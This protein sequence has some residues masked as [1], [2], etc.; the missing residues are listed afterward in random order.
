MKKNL[1]T[2]LALFVV[3]GACLLSLMSVQSRILDSV[4]AY[5]WTEGLYSKAQ[6]DAI[7]YLNTYARTRDNNEYLRFVDLLEFNETIRQ[8]REELQSEHPDANVATSLLMKNG[9][10][11]EDAQNMVWL[12]LNFSN[13]PYMAES[14]SI[15]EKGDA[16]IKEVRAAGQAISLSVTTDPA[17]DITRQIV[18]VHELN[19]EL[20]ALE[21]AFSFTLNTGA[22][23]IH[24][25]LFWTNFVTALVLACVSIL[26]GRGVVQNLRKHETALVAHGDRLTE[27]VRER[28]R[29]LEI[30][31]QELRVT[32]EA[33]DAANRAKSDF[34]AKM[35]HEIRTPM[36]AIVGMSHLALE[37]SLDAEAQS[38]VE[39][40]HL[41]SKIIISILNDILDL[42]KVEADKLVLESIDFDLDELLQTLVG[43]VSVNAD[44]KKIDILLDIDGD[45]LAA[46][47]G[48]PHRLGQV[49]TN[50]LNNAIKFSG[51]GGE[52]VLRVARDDSGS[53]GSSEMLCF[54][55][56]DNGIGIS[57]EGKAKLFQAFSQADS[58]V[59]RRYGGTGLGLMIS[60]QL[61]ELMGGKIWVE[62]EH[63]KGSVFHFTVRM[64]K[65]GRVPSIADRYPV[66]SRS[67]NVLIVEDSKV[68]RVILCHQLELLGCR[69]SV[70]CSG[71]E[72]LDFL[73]A[74]DSRPDCDLV[75]MDWRMPGMNGVETAQ[76]IRREP[77]LSS[78]AIV[79]MTAPYNRPELS[80]A[81]QGV[82]VEG[83]LHKPVTLS[84][85]H[86]TLVEALGLEPAS[87]PE[88]QR[89][90]LGPLPG[91]VGKKLLLV[92]DNEIN[93]EIAVSLLAKQGL[94]LDCVED[95]AKALER[96][97]THEYDAI[98]MD[99]QMPVMDGYET[100]REIRK[101]PRYK[102]LPVLA[103]TANVTSEDRR[104]ILECGMD[105]LIAKPIDVKKMYK[106][107]EQWLAANED[108][109]EEEVV[110]KKL[111]SC[112]ETFRE[113]DAHEGIKNCADNEK[114]YSHL[115]VKFRDTQHDFDVQFREHLARGEQKDA[116]RMAHT[117]KGDG[118]ALGM[119]ALYRA[120]A[121][122]EA[123]ATQGEETEEL[124]QALMQQ[125]LRVLGELKCI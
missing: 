61:V 25:F 6:K 10:G 89:T 27:L 105:D 116:I 42:S 120:A 22:R 71:Q 13:M 79:M 54:S 43:L 107:L 104:K 111:S 85:L 91:L 35:S 109:I 15:W 115:L 11:L 108:S 102:S 112:L 65:R 66:P 45:L 33:A 114:L 17:A 29:E 62:S 8:V 24:D 12:F 19:H 26:M 1:Y 41:S 50:L 86:D 88:K 100:T 39:K 75:L 82:R 118:A 16:L 99:C 40:I 44:D 94:E 74:G 20:E 56:R 124:L 46:Y 47:T 55:V 57:E 18:H 117:M 23:E 93:Q 21:Q 4:R 49:L 119:K 122:L 125:L 101:N 96:L 83:F 51:S 34:L 7:I 67:I 76:A 38:Y 52:V 58:S 84:A 110:A 78:V 87:E 28:T 106:T 37:G 9:L 80:A 73:L 97:K 3:F 36:N 63:G 5:V 98:L 59:A 95:G 53:R 14:I 90:D 69:C 72:A 92:E 30:N 2:I 64:Q 103:M 121:D 60:K 77:R 113:I 68:S 81:V 70:A 48:D 32:R 123:A 31:N